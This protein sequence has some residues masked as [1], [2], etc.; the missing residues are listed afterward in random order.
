MRDP[1]LA[2]RSGSAVLIRRRITRPGDTGSAETLW[3]VHVR[4]SVT[5]GEFEYEPHSRATATRTPS[6][7]PGEDDT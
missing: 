1:I 5:G 2:N 6:A 4:D 3:N 7:E